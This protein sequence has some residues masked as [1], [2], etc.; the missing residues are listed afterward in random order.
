MKRRLA[1]VPDCLDQGLVSVARL[2][3]WSWAGSLGPCMW[4][5][6]LSVAAR[7]QVTNV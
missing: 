2:V 3:G 7:Y 5:R 4:G 1:Q 6:V